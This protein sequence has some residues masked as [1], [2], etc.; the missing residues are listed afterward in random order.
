MEA[1]VAVAL[2]YMGYKIRQ[3]TSKETKQSEI[4]EQEAK[5]VEKVIEETKVALEET[6]VALEQTQKQYYELTIRLT[7]TQMITCLITVGLFAAAYGAYKAYERKKIAEERAEQ[8]LN[9]DNAWQCVVCDDNEK[10]IVYLPC[11]HLAVCQ[12]CDAELSKINLAEHQND[13]ESCPICR[14]QIIKRVKVHVQ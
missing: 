5:Q 7:R 12:K 6:K 14:S 9:M 4:H 3:D 10:T 1:L 8:V 13:K 2:F 11:N